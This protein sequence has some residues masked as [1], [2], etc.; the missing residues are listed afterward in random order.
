MRKVLFSDDFDEVT[1]GSDQIIVKYTVGIRV[2]F[3]LH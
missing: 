2:Y 1:I 3:K